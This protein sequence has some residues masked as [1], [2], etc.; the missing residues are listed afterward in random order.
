MQQNQHV[1]NFQTRQSQFEETLQ[2]IIKVTQSSF[3]QINKNHEEMGRNQNESIKNMEMNIGHLFRQI[4]VFPN[5]SGGLTGNTVE[6]PKNETCKVV[7]EGS[8]VIIEQDNKKTVQEGVIG[9]EDTR[10]QGNE[11]ERG[12][13]L[14]Y[15]IHKNSPWRIT[16]KQ[17]LA[18]PNPP[19]PDYIKP[20]FPII[21]K[22]LVQEDEAA[23]FAKFKEMLDNL[24]VSISFHEIL[25]LMPMFVKFMKVL[26]KGAKGKIGKEHVNMNEKEEVVRSQVSPPKL[27]DP[28]NFTISCNINEVNIPRALCDI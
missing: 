18:E 25:E 1:S 5:T 15:F 2:N 23:M 4:S 11:E 13:T 3:D 19:L 21:K 24:L 17:I 16:K 9:R 8:G 12:D 22:K 6:N 14:N 27:K 10:K 20:T 28:G 26:L 7:D